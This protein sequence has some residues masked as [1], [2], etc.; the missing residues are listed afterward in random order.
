MHHSLSHF[1]EALVQQAEAK[2]H[3][4][5]QQNQGAR[6]GTDYFQCGRDCSTRIGLLSLTRRCSKTYI[7]ST[8]LYSLETEGCLPNMVR[9][10]KYV[11]KADGNSI[12]SIESSFLV[13]HTRSD[14][15]T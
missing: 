14:G 3:S 8:L 11:R 5:K 1:E 13:G 15:Q 4:Q 2:R 7:Q 9:A 12:R 6:Q 10:F